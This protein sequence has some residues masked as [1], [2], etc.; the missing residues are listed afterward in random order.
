MTSVAT[1]NAPVFDLT[2]LDTFQSR[3]DAA[4]NAFRRDAGYAA[5]MARAAVVIA[6]K[7]RAGSARTTLR[8]AELAAHAECV[9]A[10][11]FACHAVSPCGVG[12]CKFAVDGMAALTVAGE[13]GTG[14]RPQADSNGSYSMAPAVTA[15]TRQL[16]TT[17][18][19]F[20]SAA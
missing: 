17:P 8:A 3:I 9:A 1:G 12:D 14:R 4:M 10:G 7:R 15:L 6:T 5:S 16:A 13:S 18:Q 11:T 20:G 19:R 2:D